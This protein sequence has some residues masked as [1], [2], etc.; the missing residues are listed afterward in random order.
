MQD[1]GRAGAIEGFQVAFAEGAEGHAAA[2]AGTARGAQQQCVDL[3]L[4]D[5]ADQRA[6]L[7]QGDATTQRLASTLRN[8]I[9]TALAGADPA[10]DTLAELGISSAAKG[11]TLSADSTRLDKVLDSGF[12]DVARLFS[13]DNGLAARISS[14]LDRYTSSDGSL[15]SR[16]DSLKA[17]AKS[18]SDQQDALDLRMSMLQSRYM[19]Q[20]TALDSLMSGL[21][22]T[23]SFLTQQLANLSS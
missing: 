7:L 16:T 4:G 21:S 22:N 12:D 18:I 15:Q 6:G 8:E 20:F 9:N 23:S 13:G 14:S 3:A 11:G 19:A 10:L 17:Q 1:A 2:K 5:G